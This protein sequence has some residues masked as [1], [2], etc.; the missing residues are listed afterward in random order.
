[1]KNKVRSVTPEATTAGIAPG[2]R[3]FAIPSVIGTEIAR[4]LSES[5][6]FLE[7]EPGARMIEEELCT[8]FGVS[9]SPIR[10]AFR[11]LESDGLIVRTARRGVRVTPMSRTDLDEVYACRV[12]LEGLAAAE[13]A[14]RADDAS[15]AHLRSLLA[16][17]QVALDARDVSTFFHRNVAFTRAV[18]AASGN[19][20]LMRIV[21]GIEKQALRYRYLAHLRTFEMLELSF[22]GHSDVCAAIIARKPLLARRRGERLMRRAHGVIA[23][24]LAEA[25][26]TLR[27]RSSRPVPESGEAGAG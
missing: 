15:V 22:E 7:I 24:A 5:I 25:Y 2:E 26:P 18:H 17:M 8:R 19:S 1:M 20:T 14:R 11:M 21:A 6:I 10:E 4:V 23:R 3:T 9:R 13:A 27:R 16:E 12:A